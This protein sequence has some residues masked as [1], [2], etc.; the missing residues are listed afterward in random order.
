MWLGLPSTTTVTVTCLLA[1]PYG[2]T[3]RYCAVAFAPTS[4]PPTLSFN[5]ILLPINDIAI[6]PH[7]ILKL[8]AFMDAAVPLMARSTALI[9]SGGR[10][11]DGNCRRMRDQ[12]S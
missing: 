10:T 7:T 5:R 12:E 2:A 3:G 11:P 6:H 1:I 9:R 8:S 4:T